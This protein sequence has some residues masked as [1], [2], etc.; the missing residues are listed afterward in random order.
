[1]IIFRFL[2]IYSTKISTAYGICWR[3]ITEF[4]CFLTVGGTKLP[5]SKA[6]SNKRWLIIMISVSELIAYSCICFVLLYVAFSYFSTFQMIHGHE[7]EQ[8]MEWDRKV[9]KASDQQAV[10]TSHPICILFLFFKVSQ[11]IYLHF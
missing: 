6:V 1:M 7:S 11:F 8:L 2:P 9:A 10:G 5:S 4:E 3:K